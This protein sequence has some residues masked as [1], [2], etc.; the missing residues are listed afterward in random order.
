MRFEKAKADWRGRLGGERP[1]LV[2]FL[3]RLR[4][5]ADAR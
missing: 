4:Y 5:P 1:S 2:R 3:G